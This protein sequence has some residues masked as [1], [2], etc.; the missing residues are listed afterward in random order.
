MKVLLFFS[1]IVVLEC[2]RL[3]IYKKTMGKTVRSSTINQKRSKTTAEMQVRKNVCTVKTCLKCL[4]NIMNPS[5]YQPKF[6]R[7]VFSLS[8][9][10]P[11]QIGQMLGF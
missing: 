11:R 1:I 2:S 6:C 8:N 4:K 5:I 7:V 3:N 10:C 9:C